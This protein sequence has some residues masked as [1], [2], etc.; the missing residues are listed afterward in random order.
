M[1]PKNIGKNI[2]IFYFKLFCIILEA[3]FYVDDKKI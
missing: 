1:Q 3:D 2:Y